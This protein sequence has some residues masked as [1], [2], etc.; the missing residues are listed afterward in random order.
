[1]NPVPGFM[2]HPCK[3]FYT[4][5]STDIDLIDI[6]QLGKQHQHLYLYLYLYQSA[7]IKVSTLISTFFSLTTYVQVG[8]SRKLK[9]YGLSI[10]SSS[11]LSPLGVPLPY[12]VHVRQELAEEQELLDVRPLSYSSHT[13]TTSQPLPS[14]DSLDVS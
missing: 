2:F 4:M 5:I 13:H 14:V 10:F 8:Y 1:M 6:T 12:P 11:V 9:S 3:T 7:A